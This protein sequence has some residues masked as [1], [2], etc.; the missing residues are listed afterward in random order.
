M[1][2]PATS[3]GGTP[4]TT[5]LSTPSTREPDPGCEISTREFKA[6]RRITMPRLGRSGTRIPVCRGHDLRRPQAAA[7]ASGRCGATM[8]CRR[9]GQQIP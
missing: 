3:T 5:S 7:T 9:S 1:P 6:R 2:T 8:W 4:C